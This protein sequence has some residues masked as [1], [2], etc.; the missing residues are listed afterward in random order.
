VQTLH[1]GAFLE[2]AGDA[3]PV[4]G[5][6]LVH[7]VLEFVVLLGRPPALLGEG[8]L[9]IG[10]VGVEGDHSD[11]LVHQVV[12][13]GGRAVVG[14]GVVVGAAEEGDRCPLHVLRQ[15]GEVFGGDYQLLV[16]Q[17]V[18]LPQLPVVRRQC[19]LLGEAVELLRGGKG[20]PGS[21]GGLKCLFDLHKL[22]SHHHNS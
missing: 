10:V 16:V 12:R 21:G 5:A 13:G 19:V 22:W 20:R 14:V 1:V 8:A 7:E 9:G 6:V 3:F 11:H 17:R 18:L 4:A 15:R 2:E